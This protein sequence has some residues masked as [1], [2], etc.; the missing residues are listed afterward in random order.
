M[1]RAKITDV[2]EELTRRASAGDRNPISPAA[3]R[4]LTIPYHP[5]LALEEA[6]IA[7]HYPESDP[8]RAYAAIEEAVR[9]R[10]AES[11]AES[12][13]LLA[14]LLENLSEERTQPSVGVV[15][16]DNPFA[17]PLRWNVVRP[18]A[19]A[20]KLAAG[21]PEGIRESLLQ[22]LANSTMPEETRRNIVEALLK[23]D[24]ARAEE[25]E[26]ALREEQTTLRELGTSEWPAL[27][28][29]AGRTWA[30]WALL[31][32]ERLEIERGE[33]GGHLF[34][35]WPCRLDG[36]VGVLAALAALD[37]LTAKKAASANA[38]REF[39][40]RFVDANPGF[41]LALGSAAAWLVELERRSC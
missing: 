35:S 7:E 8:G 30:G 9:S 5:L 23:I 27:A 1:A 26:Q 36:E 21:V 25:L 3:P 31:S 40:A 33:V 24:A 11:V 22:G 28:E 10:G 37:V 6:M 15:R 32:A 14:G 2:V 17:R 4:L 19:T 39:L 18:E 13:A 29:I 34:G 41:D 16:G 38:Q 20:E 12:K